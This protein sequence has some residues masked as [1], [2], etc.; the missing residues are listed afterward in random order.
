[1]AEFDAEVIAVPPF[2]LQFL[3][4]GSRFAFAAG[5]RRSRGCEST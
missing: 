4:E 1:L 2:F 5:N 3:A